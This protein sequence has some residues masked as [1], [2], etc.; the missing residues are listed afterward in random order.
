MVQCHIRL[1]RTFLWFHNTCWRSLHELLPQY[2]RRNP[3]IPLRDGCHGLL[4]KKTYPCLLP[5]L[6]RRSMHIGRTSGWKR[7]HGTSSG[8]FTKLQLNFYKKYHITCNQKLNYF[9]T[10]FNVF[11]TGIFNTHRQVRCI[12]GLQHSLLILRRTVSHHFEVH[13]HRYLQ[14]GGKIW[15]DSSTLGILNLYHLY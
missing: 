6:T 9:Y 15:I 11:E 8:L 2:I 3:R 4:G 10:I 7:T 12:G 14:P 1:L 5:D 13:I